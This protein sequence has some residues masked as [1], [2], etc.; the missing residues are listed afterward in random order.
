VLF[1]DLVQDIYI[2]MLSAETYILRVNLEL[3]TVAT[4]NAQIAK[5]LNT[6]V[7][8]QTLL[9]VDDD[10]SGGILAGGGEDGRSLAD[11]NVN[12]RST[13]LLVQSVPS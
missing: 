11:Y 10:G 6:G 7:C 9:F 3:D 4:V 13:L 12:A 5:C 2:S 8:D 1:L